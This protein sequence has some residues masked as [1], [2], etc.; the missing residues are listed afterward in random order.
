[1]LLV[2]VSLKAGTVTYAVEEV[3]REGTRGSRVSFIDT[4]TDYAHADHGEQIEAGELE[5][6]AERRA[7]VEVGRQCGLAVR[8]VSVLSMGAVLAAKE[9]AFATGSSSAGSGGRVVPI[10]AMAEGRDSVVV[11][12]TIA[13]VCVGGRRVL[14]LSRGGALTEAGLCRLGAVGEPAEEAHDG[15]RMRERRERRSGN[16]FF[17]SSVSRDASTRVCFFF[18]AGGEVRR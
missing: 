12:S 10:G 13:A 5:P 6:L 3:Y 18:F 17:Y 1:M 8:V 2:V 15:G 7:F 4:K 11:A 9:S 16:G 14:H